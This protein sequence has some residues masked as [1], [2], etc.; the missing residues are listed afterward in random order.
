MEEFKYHSTFSSGWKRISQEKSESDEK[1]MEELLQ[2]LS[3]D[4]TKK[5]VQ[6]YDTKVSLPAHTP[7]TKA[8]EKMVSD[9]NVQEMIHEATTNIKQTQSDIMTKLGELQNDL[10]LLK[11]LLNTPSI[12]QQKQKKTTTNKLSRFFK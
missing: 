7:V 12:Q 8:S 6:A 5:P 10:A 2:S 3:L 1:K 11:Q 4:S 9:T